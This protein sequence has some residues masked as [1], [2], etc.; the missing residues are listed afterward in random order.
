MNR[1]KQKKALLIA[2]FWGKSVHVGVNRIDRFK[3]WLIAE[4]YMVIIIKGGIKNEIQK[5]DW[6]VEIS[7]S[8]LVDNITT[9][10]INLSSRIR[11]KLF[12][13][14]WNTLVSILS[15]PD[16]NRLW[17]RKVLKQPLVKK[18]IED[19]NFVISSSPPHSSHIVAFQISTKFNIPL[20]VDLRDGWL[21]EPLRSILRNS[22][23]RFYLEGKLEKKILTHS[24]MIFVTSDKWKKLLIRRFPKFNE[25]TAVL[26]NAYPEFEFAKKSIPKSKPKDRLEFLHAGRFTGSSYLRKADILLTPLFNAIIGLKNPLKISILLIGRIKRKDQGTLN[27]WIQQFRKIHSDIIINQHITRMKLFNLFENVDGL[28]L[29]STSFSAIPSKTFEY[30]KSQKPIL[31]VTLKDSAIWEIAIDIPQMFVYDYTSSKKDYG[32]IDKFLS[33]CRS[34]NFE[35]N[36]PIQYSEEHLSK[37]F[38]RSVEG[39]LD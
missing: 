13:Y 6:G 19:I 10:L 11:T 1:K 27:K 39:C 33:A 34:G 8:N 21:D 25:K 36:I 7:V 15:I 30:I 26:T 18:N 16:E 4:D 14:I 22:K 31:A 35:I 23:L 2:P 32:I 28:L 17:A 12:L 3:R 29:L 9:R 24:E 5:F 38:M 20:I 37:I